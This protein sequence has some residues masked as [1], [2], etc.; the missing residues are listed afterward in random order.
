MMTVIHDRERLRTKTEWSGAIVRG[1]S[2]FLCCC[3]L[4]LQ[5]G[6]EVDSYLDPSRTGRFMHTPTTIPVLERLDV[7]EDDVHPWGETTEVIPEDLLP[8]DLTYVIVPGDFLTVEVYES[9]ALGQLR[10]ISRRVDAAG[11]FRIPDVGDVMAAG[12]TAQEF[13][14]KVRQ[15]LEEELFIDPYVNVMVEEGTAFT[16]TLEGFTAGPGMYR[17]RHPDFRLSEAVAAAGGL[18]QA[19]RTVYVIRRVPLTEEIKPVYERDRD[20][21]R[22]ERRDPRPR[23]TPPV[24]IEDLIDDLDDDPSP[25]PAVFSSP[26]DGLG[27]GRSVMVDVDDL[28]P[29]RMPRQAVVDIDEAMDPQERE[30]RER[31]REMFIYDQERGEWVRTFHQPRRDQDVV[32]GRRRG[33]DPSATYD[34]PRLLIERIIEIPAPSVRRGMGQFDIVIRPKDRIVIEGPQPGTVYISGEISRPG[35]FNL[36]QD[37]GRLTLSRLVAAA[38]DLGGLAIPE[39]VDLVR[40]VGPNR[41]ATVRLNLAAI[42]RRTEPDIYLKPDDHVIIGTSFFAT[43]LAVIRNGFRATYGFGFLLDRNFGNDVFGAPPVNRLGGGF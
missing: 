3:F 2:L 4:A 34:E 42:R 41:E 28:E 12:Y 37:G 39:R 30:Q 21:M 36:P 23:T 35:V 22:D 11:F 20:E 9:F 15:R 18:P 25:N 5:F 27:G 16:F 19:A 10:P 7:I 26:T 1:M 40:K 38:G 43:P 14:D 29:V 8:S 31:S 17:I 6:C 32:S 13:E 33:D 24:D